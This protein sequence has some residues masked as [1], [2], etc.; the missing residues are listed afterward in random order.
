MSKNLR[1]FFAA[2]LAVCALVVAAGD[3]AAFDVRVAWSPVAGA[4]GYRLY[5]RTAGNPDG[6]RIDVGNPAPGADGI[7][8]YVHT[9]LGESSS[10]YFTVTSYD[11]ARE[12]A[13]SNERIITYQTV[14]GLLDSDGDGLL[15]LLEDRD[16]DMVTDPNETD[17]LRADTDGDG[18]DDGLEILRGW[19]PLDPNDPIGPTAAPT[20]VRTSA[21]PTPAATSAPPATATSAPPSPAPA[22]TSGAGTCAAPIAIPADGGT[23]TGTTSGTGALRGSCAG[24]S[25]GPERVYRWTPTVSGRAVLETCSGT[26]TNFDTIVYLRRADCAAGAEVGCNDD[27]GSCVTA[28]PSTYHGSRLAPT[29]TAGETYFIVVDGFNESGA[30]VL[31]VIPPTPPVAATPAATP[32]GPTRT[33]TPRPTNTSPPTLTPTRTATRTPTRT[34][35]RTRTA[36]PVRTATRTPTPLATATAISTASAAATPEAT[37]TPAATPTPIATATPE[38]GGACATATEIPAEGGAFYGTTAADGT[39]E[40]SGACG[41]TEVAAETVFKWTPAASGE[42]VVST[43]SDT[44]TTFDSAVYVRSGDCAGGAEI[45]CNNNAVGCNTTFGGPPRGSR[46]RFDVV[47]GATYFLVVD[48]VKGGAGDFL[49]KVFAPLSTLRAPDP[50]ATAPEDGDGPGSTD[51][52]PVGEPEPMGPSAAYVCRSVEPVSDGLEPEEA[53][54]A[55]VSDPFA[56]LIGAAAEPRALC[57]PVTTGGAPAGTTEP[58][59]VRHEVEIDA[60]AATELRTVRL[61]NAL[62]EIVVDVYAARAALEAPA[63]VAPP[64]GAAN[65]GDAIDPHAC[66]QVRAASEVRRQNLML[67]SPDEVAKFRVSLPEELC[68]RAA[69]ADGTPGSVSLCYAARRRSSSEDPALRAEVEIASVLGTVIGRL[70][71]VDQVCLQSTIVSDAEA[72]YTAP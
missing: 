48:G 25:S 66:Y 45:A 59:L 16:L 26:A 22:P 38:A 60:F 10:H 12:S 27:T 36:T 71:T 52:P 23:F 8:R 30:F 5:V 3:A 18:I 49:L 21:A 15:D 7:I 69:S 51:E 4:G 6:A 64:I 14:A 37:R 62:G 17:R 46:V 47:A 57:L 28:E 19:N 50:D 53:L 39:S 67:A 41:D 31:R 2:A 42:A 56:E 58:A 34:P 43:C 33:A 24:T 72:A 61:R 11:G 32:T 63:T 65:A 20:P 40:L 70:Q 68:V 35:T 1:L 54:A 13:A 55:Q 44:G 9:G 29:V